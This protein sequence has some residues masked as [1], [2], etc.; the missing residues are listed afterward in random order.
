MRKIIIFLIILLFLIINPVN[1]I[2]SYGV[3]GQF[4]GK[5]SS[6]R[7]NIETNT[8]GS[9]EW[10]ASAIIQPYNYGSILFDSKHLYYVK[11]IGGSDN[12]NIEAR[13]ITNGSLAWSNSVGHD[14]LNIVV[15]ENEK[16]YYLWYTPTWGETHVNAYNQNGTNYIDCIGL[17]FSS[18]VNGLIRG[19]MK[20]HN[21]YIYVGINDLM[22]FEKFNVGGCFISGYY[23]DIEG[24]ETGTLIGDYGY[25][26]ND[27]EL[28]SILLEN[29]SLRYRTTDYNQSGLSY[30]AYSPNNSTIYTYKDY[31]DGVEAYFANNGSE[32]WYYEL[33]P[34]HYINTVTLGVDFNNHIIFGTSNGRLISLNGND[35]TEY[36]NISLSPSLFSVSEVV[37]DK[38]NIIYV[39]DSEYDFAVY[40]NGTIKWSNFVGDHDYDI[41]PSIDNNGSVYFY[42][43]SHII[44]YAS[45]IQSTTISGNVK[46]QDINGS[47]AN[48]E[49]V[50]VKIN[51]L[52]YDYTD[53]LGN[54]IIQIPSGTYNLNFNKSSAFST[55]NLTNIVS[56]SSN[57]NVVLDYSK[58]H[59]SIPNL[60]GNYIQSTYSH[61][62]KN[63]QLWENPNYVWCIYNFDDN[64]QTN[65]YKQ[66]EYLQNNIFSCEL[67]QN[68]NYTF[69]MEY[70]DIYNYNLSK[71]HP[72]LSGARNFTNNNIYI[73]EGAIIDELKT[74]SRS[75]QI[76]REKILKNYFWD[77][78]FLMFI[79]FISIYAISFSK[80]R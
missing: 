56:P 25:Y 67:I 14:P 36:F 24:V 27:D 13:Y 66:S 9:V 65:F 59:L 62:F 30:I 29:M 8:N 41:L 49:N 16:I 55:Y 18:T 50:Y 57:N 7:V 20:I 40:E 48:L 2:E 21:N 76:E 10:T 78:L 47:L 75:S 73:R 54:Y 37:I 17:A 22:T 53:S 45:E 4:A 32:K 63:L 1:A 42:N 26:V 71:W 28:V 68:S 51:D 5:Y 64:N 80:R 74:I 12:G 11:D 3:Y 44:K 34:A 15:D 46:F 69:Y 39:S 79:I 35:G 58:P 19:D 61:N 70:S 72:F 60:N 6:N 31:P 77:I 52:Y 33:N 43:G 38:N 23:Q